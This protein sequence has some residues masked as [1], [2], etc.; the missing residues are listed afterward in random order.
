MEK[1]L[2]S[3]EAVSSLE[4][5]INSEEFSSRL[6]E[7]MSLWFDNKGYVNL[8][9][10]Y[11]KYSKEELTHAKWS[12]EFL[13]SYGIKPRL[14]P[15]QTPE[16]VYADCG[17]ILDATLAHELL[18]TRECENLAVNAL[19]RGEI[20]L[21]TLGLKYCAEQIEEINKA[22]NLIDSYKLTSCMLVFDQ[23]VGENY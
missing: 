6:Y 14:K 16:A 17:D 19:K 12:K 7:D 13:L 18:I 22:K 21:Y 3:S 5:R 1:Q 10:L 4:Q 2:L 20:T 9:K 8:A 23:Y 11:D 15:L